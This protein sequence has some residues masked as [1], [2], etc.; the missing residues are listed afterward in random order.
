MHAIHYQLRQL[1]ACA[2][3]ALVSM[4]SISCWCV[5]FLRHCTCCWCCCAFFISLLLLIFLIFL[6]LCVH[7]LHA[8][9]RSPPLC[10][11]LPH[12]FNYYFCCWCLKMVCVVK[13]IG[14]LH[15]NRQYKT[16]AIESR[17]AEQQECV[18]YC[19]VTYRITFSFA[20]IALHSTLSHTHGM[21]N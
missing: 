3:A 11:L 2:R 10:A 6:C 12:S 8:L 16:I 1:Y 15:F 14:G 5:F 21:V 17:Y 7:M 18:Q 20:W 13:H 9:C 4:H 19:I